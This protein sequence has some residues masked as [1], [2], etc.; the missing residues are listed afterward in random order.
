MEKVKNDP[1]TYLRRSNLSPRGKE[2]PPKTLPMSSERVKEFLS[3]PMDERFYVDLR[4][5]ISS[6]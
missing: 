1:G 3:S 4:A 6:N 2:I 5:I